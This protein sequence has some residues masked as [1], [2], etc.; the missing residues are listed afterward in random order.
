MGIWVAV[1]L[2]ITWVV[3][4]TLFPALQWILRT[5]T[6]L[7]RPSAGGWIE[8]FAAWLPL[9]ELPLPLAAGRLR[10]PALRLRS[11]G[12]LRSARRD[13]RD[14]RAHRSRRVHRPR[15]RAL[16]RRQKAGKGDPGDVDDG[17]LDH[18]TPGKRFRARHADGAR[19]LPGAARD[20]SRGGGRHRSDRDPA[21]DPLSGRPGRRLAG[22]GGGPRADRRR[23]RGHA[24]AGADAPAFRAAPRA[25]AVAPQRDQPGD[26]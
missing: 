5:P 19:S 4:F 24:L 6:R 12:S 17:R 7:E 1:G 8:R 11:R 21:L 20:R 16:P 18:G 25:R 22:G 15:R 3:V 23:S 10:A 14:A 26:G 13:S 2:A 9:L